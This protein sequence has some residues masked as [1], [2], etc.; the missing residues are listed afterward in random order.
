MEC[1]IL[2][3]MILHFVT[4]DVKGYSHLAAILH[5]VLSRH[6]VLEYVGTREH[7]E[8]QQGPCEG[9]QRKICM[10]D[11]WNISLGKGSTPLPWT[12]ERSKVSTLSLDMIS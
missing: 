8:V 2:L 3:I 12:I 1:C 5:D 6:E 10:H 4:L 7:C 11:Q 9:L